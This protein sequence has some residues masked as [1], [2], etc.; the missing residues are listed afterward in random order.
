MVD[1]FKSE[2]QI[3]KIAAQAEGKLKR[4]PRQGFRGT[5]VPQRGDAFANVGIKPEPMRDGRDIADL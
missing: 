5:A 4:V 1:R 3:L 2:N